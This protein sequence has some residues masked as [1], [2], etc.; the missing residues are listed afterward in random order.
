MDELA[1]LDQVNKSWDDC[2]KC[3]KYVGAFMMET[4]R[5]ALLNNGISV[6]SRDVFI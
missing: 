5:Q 3:S 1:I 6:S 2:G 4:I